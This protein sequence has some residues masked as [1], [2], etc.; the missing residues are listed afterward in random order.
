M[1][2]SLAK[3]TPGEICREILD[4]EAEVSGLVA[5]AFTTGGELVWG[6]TGTV[7]STGLLLAL[8]V[9]HA[10]AGRMNALITAEVGGHA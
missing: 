3:D 1:I 7:H 10:E 5:F 6:M 8:Q 9:L 2:G 4:N